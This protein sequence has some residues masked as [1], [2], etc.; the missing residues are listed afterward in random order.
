MGNTF[1]E[2]Q[3]IAREALDI[4][5]GNLVYGDLVD[6]RFDGNFVGKVGDTISIRSRAAVKSKYYNGSISKQDINEVP[7]PVKLDRW[8]DTSVAIGTKDLTLS[9]QDFRTQVLEPIMIGMANDVNSDIAA[10][11]YANAATRITATADPTDLKDIA[12]VAKTLDINKAP[13]NDRS[14]VLSPE[15]KY[16]YALTDNL[17]KVAY[18]GDNVTLRDALLGKI[19]SVN[20]YMDQD[21]P[22]TSAETAGTATSYKVTCNAGDDKVTVT[23]ATPAAGTVKKGDK[24]IVNGRIYT[25]SAD[26][27][28]ASGNGTINTVEEIGETITTA[29]DVVIVNKP[30]SVAFQKEAIAFVNVPLALPDGAVR[31]YVASAKNVS[32]RVVIGYDMDKKTDVLSID[33]LYGLAVER[34]EL[35][36]SLA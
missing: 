9:I 36:V 27:T 7:I 22:D 29:T 30:T 6:R 10:F 11:A 2:P 23:S 5:V 32:V 16:R 19:Y 24:F 21:N 8:R 31:A 33:C 28:F 26:A 13:K 34:P 12:K 35:I 15:H 1:L 14:L 17:S 4:L 18:A 20:T 3:I 25:A